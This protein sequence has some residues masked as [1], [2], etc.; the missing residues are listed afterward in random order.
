MWGSANRLNDGVLGEMT[1]LPEVKQA[2]E[3]GA[4]VQQE[5][6]KVWYLVFHF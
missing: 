6:L 2:Y 3:H 4:V 1:T 5:E